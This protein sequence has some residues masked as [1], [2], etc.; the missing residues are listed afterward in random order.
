[1]RDYIYKY[2]KIIEVDSCVRCEQSKA[3]EGRR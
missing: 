1:M 3:P 2:L